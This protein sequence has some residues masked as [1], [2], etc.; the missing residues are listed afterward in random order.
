MFT[1][2]IYGFRAFIL[3]FICTGAKSENGVNV[4][5]QIHSTDQQ[6]T[7]R[8]CNGTLLKSIRERPADTQYMDR[9]H[10]H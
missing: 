10:H 4:H 5:Q 6:T 7:V 2:F 9:P 8:Q 3:G 1:D